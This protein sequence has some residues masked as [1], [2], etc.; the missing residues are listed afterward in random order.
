MATLRR[1]AGWL[2]ATGLVLFTV[3]GTWWL[4]SWYAPFALAAETYTPL[5]GVDAA[6][7]ER[8]RRETG[9]DDE[10]LACI[11]VSSAQLETML[12]SLRS[13]Y[14]TNKTELLAQQAAVADQAAVIRVL[15]SA[16]RIGEDVLSDLAAARQELTRRQNAYATL[17]ETPHNDA[18]TGLSDDEL[19]VA[20]RVYQRFGISMPFRFL[21]L[22][23]NQDRSVTS[24]RTR[25][26]KRLAMARDADE[27]SAARTEYLQDIE[28][29]IGA[30]N[31]Q[32]LNALKTY[33]GDAS[34][35][36]V[37]AVQTVLPEESEG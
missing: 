2:S 27:R 23:D 22:T 5:D 30:A 9:L 35:R 37:A 21:E 7:M 19:A 15:Q 11:D 28:G 12:A 3:C 33:L 1:N 34:E 6:L 25:Y 24:V 18:L 29:A 32:E 17:L 26:F 14:E 8:L 31:I 13:W 20:E 16:N 36:V 10:V 4:V